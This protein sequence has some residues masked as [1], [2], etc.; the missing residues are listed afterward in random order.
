MI[1]VIIICIVVILLGLF[2]SIPLVVLH[3]SFDK[4]INFNRIWTGDE[5]NVEEDHFFLTTDDGLK[6]SVYEVVVENPRGVIV[7]MGGMFTPSATIYLAH[8]R[9]FKENGYATIMFDMRAHGESDGDRICLGYK[10]PLDVKAVV[11]Y[12]KEK[13]SYN[14]VPIVVM[15]LS[16]GAVTA[17]NSMGE[18]PE[19][20]GV[21][22]LSAYSSYEDIFYENMVKQ[23][24]RLLS[25]IV[26][27]FVPLA[28]R[29]KYKVNPYLIKPVKEIKKIGNRPVL[30]MHTKGDTDASFENFERILKEAP[31]HVETF[32]RKGNYHS[33][34]LHNVFIQPERDVEYANC[35][36][37]FLSRHF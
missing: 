6:I 2:L 15:G 7:C 24:P 4:H 32:V 31:G 29:I 37:G 22:S 23:S 26:K 18:M 14:N 21:I 9:L 13:P 36:L 33:I 16:M 30:L 19:I 10:E 1:A 12:I 34:I 8:A 28:V 27:I 3:K 5:F 11:K 17:I 25:R 35:L 20:D